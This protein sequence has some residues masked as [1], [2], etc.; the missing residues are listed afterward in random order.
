MR[1]MVSDGYGQLQYSNQDRY[2]GEWVDGLRHGKGIHN[3]NNG[4]K[5]IGEWINGVP[6]G[7]GTYCT[8]TGILYG[9][10]WYNGKVIPA[11]SALIS[12]SIISSDF[13]QK[14]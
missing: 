14:L 7:S 3:Y 4:D 11:L 13:L 10:S 6:S 8:V 5:Y 2:D 1:K 12:L 9:G